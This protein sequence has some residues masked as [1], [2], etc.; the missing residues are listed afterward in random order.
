[1][2]EDYVHDTWLT[3]IHQHALLLWSMLAWCHIVACQLSRQQHA[4][5]GQGSSMLWL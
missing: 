5:L 4:L 3:T 2:H 1:M